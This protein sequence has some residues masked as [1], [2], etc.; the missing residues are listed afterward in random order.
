[1]A[2]DKDMIMIIK[3]DD[4]DWQIADVKQ[5]F[6]SY[7]LA[8]SYAE[9][10]IVTRR[11]SKISFKLAKLTSNILSNISRESKFIEEKLRSKMEGM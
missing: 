3:D 5:K 10:M 2:K 11:E 8:E 4:G 7:A 6:A 1:M 9:G